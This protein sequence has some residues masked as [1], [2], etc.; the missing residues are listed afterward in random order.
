MNWFSR[1]LPADWLVWIINVA[2]MVVLQLG[3]IEL[4]RY[5]QSWYVENEWWRALTAHWVHVGWVHLLLNAAGFAIAIGIARPNWQIRL[6]F[7]YLLSIAI[8][9]SLMFSWLNPELGWY[10]GFSGVLFGVY[11]VASVQLFKSEPVVAVLLFGIVAGKVVLEQ[12]SNFDVGSSDLIGA[13]VIVDA[14]LYG[15]IGGLLIALVSQ[16]HTIVQN[17]Q[18]TR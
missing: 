2:V 10:V 7:A 14:H 4:L 15:L 18:Q 17:L 1:R 3:T 12:F 5:Q 16:A 9:I 13:P 6:W 8:F 11:I